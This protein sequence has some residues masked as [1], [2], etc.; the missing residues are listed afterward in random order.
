MM[1]DHPLRVAWVYHGDGT[2]ELW[3]ASNFPFSWKLEKVLFRGPLVDR[4]PLSH[5]SR[6]YFF[7]AFSE[8]DSK[9]G[10]GGL[11]TAETLTGEWERHAECPIST[12]CRYARSAG[13]ILQ[14]RGRLLR[15]VQDCTENYGR[16]IHVQEILEL[17]PDAYCDRHV[18]S[19]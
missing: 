10:F 17:S 9:P 3:R 7:T 19:I 16:R 13:P 5:N 1:P 15:P 14:V 2:V 8:R 18:H 6:W 12:D 11:F 4:T